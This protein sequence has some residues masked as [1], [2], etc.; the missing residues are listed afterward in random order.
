LK[1]SNR[2]QNYIFKLINRATVDESNLTKNTVANISNVDSKTYIS[3]EVAND[4]DGDDS[5]KGEQEDDQNFQDDNLDKTYDA[6]P[7]VR[8]APIGHQDINL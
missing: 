5:D 1:K 3:T 2:I 6:L 7:S 8:E 4:V